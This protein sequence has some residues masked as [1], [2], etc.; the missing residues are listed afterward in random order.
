MARVPITRAGQQASA[1]LLPRLC[2]PAMTSEADLVVLG[3]QPLPPD[4][5]H[6]LSGQSP[7]LVR[8]GSEA[9]V[10]RGR[11]FFQSISLQESG[12]ALDSLLWA[13]RE[14]I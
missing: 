12:M 8:Q 3:G 14:F 5:G 4:S 6:S 10:R 1:L 11:L 9:P 7:S 13:D 2:P